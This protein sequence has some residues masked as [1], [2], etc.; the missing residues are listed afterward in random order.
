MDIS[1]KLLSVKNDSNWAIGLCVDHRLIVFSWKELDSADAKLRLLR[2]NYIL[3]SK[4]TFNKELLDD[5]VAFIPK[6]E[7]VDVVLE[8]VLKDGF[9]SLIQ[10]V[11]AVR[12]P[13]VDEAAIFIFMDELIRNFI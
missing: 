5:I 10:V 4:L 2:V 13:K 6:P 1:S 11:F 7:K 8:L 12:K 3:P 9:P